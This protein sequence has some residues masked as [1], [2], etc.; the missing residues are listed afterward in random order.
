[1]YNCDDSRI[2]YLFRHGETNQNVEDRIMGQLE[3]IETKFTNKGYKQIK[4]IS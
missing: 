3:R 1:M 4:T 2:I